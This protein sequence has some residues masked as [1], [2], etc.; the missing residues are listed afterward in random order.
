MGNIQGDSGGPLMCMN[1]RGDWSLVGVYS[2]LSYACTEPGAYTNVETYN[3]WIH[4][5]INTNSW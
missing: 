3:D 5:V 1:S 2:F 4:K